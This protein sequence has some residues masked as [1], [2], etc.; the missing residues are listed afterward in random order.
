MVK[1]ILN[2]QL[3]LGIWIHNTSPRL[4]GEGINML[5]AFLVRNAN[6]RDDLKITIACL[7]WM[8][9][10]IIDF[11]E[12]M[13]IDTTSI[14][15]IVSHKRVPYIYRLRN[16]KQK[17]KKKKKNYLNISKKLRTFEKNIFK[18]LAGT[19]NII[20]LAVKAI[21]ISPF[22]ILAMFLLFFIYISKWITKLGFVKKINQ[23]ILS[24]KNKL[25]TKAYG[26]AKKLYEN[27]QENEFDRLAN[28][29]KSNNDVDVW[30]LSYPSN[31]YIKHFKKPVVVS[32]PDMVYLNFPI[33][34]LMAFG[35]KTLKKIHN[36]IA[37]TI[38]SATA[39]I[40][41]SD[42]VSKKHVKKFFRGKD[43]MVKVINHANVDTINELEK[44]KLRTNMEYIDLSNRL[45][46]NYI[47]KITIKNNDS[48]SVYLRGVHWEDIQYIFI[49]S[50]V[51]PHKNYLNIFKAYEKVLRED[52]RNIKLIITGNP[53]VMEQT[54]RFIDERKLYY[55]IIP[56]TAIPPRIHAAFYC[57]ASLT[58]VPTLFEGG[59]PFCFSESLS[60]NTPVIM[61]DIPV[62]SEMIKDD[63]M[64]NEMLFD[65]YD[66]NQIRKKI[67]WALD[68]NEMLLKKQKVIYNN[69]KKR[70]WDIVANEYIDC[71]EEVVKNC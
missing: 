64:K 11:F 45:I 26:L 71:F 21:I 56:I 57:K 31:T 40:S 10:P 25:N 9:K 15:F 33:E 16:F 19:N 61:S 24:I 2:K 42:Y 27:M 1:K 67:N 37:E 65:P 55:D 39:T 36:D 29:C 4:M 6:K 41:Y 48:M 17:K 8:R 5:L 58:V 49:S 38:A 63:E 35:D 53:A 51:R 22:L 50:Q 68:N 12:E 34:F 62:T 46:K 18:N 69:M 32:V 44:L 43:N 66:V 28:K 47:R 59:F 3:K 14:N 23:N 30:F 60:V 70:T 7:S 13:H 52:Y 20:L 54:Q